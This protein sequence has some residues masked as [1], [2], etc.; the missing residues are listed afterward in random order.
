MATYVSQEEAI[1]ARATQVGISHDLVYDYFDK[2]IDRV[3]EQ[4][5]GK[6]PDLRLEE[7]EQL[8]WDHFCKLVFSIVH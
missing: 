1:Y 4:H 2:M 3:T 6:G 7:A 8:V 5:P